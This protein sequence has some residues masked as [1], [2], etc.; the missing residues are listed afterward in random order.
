[1]LHN[2]EMFLNSGK[3]LLILGL[4]PLYVQA[5]RNRVPVVRSSASF[6]KLSNLRTGLNSTSSYIF[7]T[8]LAMLFLACISRSP[9][10]CC[11]FY[12]STVLFILKDVWRF[13]WDCQEMTILQLYLIRGSVLPYHQHIHLN[14]SLWPT[15]ITRVSAR[16]RFNFDAD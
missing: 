2:P 8:N 7:R 10:C 5:E 6:T 15:S 3:K 4:I 13:D 1:M 9:E 16:K 11:V 12:M 14:A